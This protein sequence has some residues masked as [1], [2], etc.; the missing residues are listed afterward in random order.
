[1][2]K[3]PRKRKPT[4][5]GGNKGFNY[6]MLGGNDQIMGSGSLEH[7]T[8][9]ASKNNWGIGRLTPIRFAEIKFD[10][11][12]LLGAKNASDN[13]WRLCSCGLGSYEHTVAAKGKSPE[14]VKCNNCENTVARFAAK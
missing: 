9:L 8:E 6:V 13:I 10:T 1:M 4:F 3:Q 12:K 7:C 14:R 5:Y 11:R 2:T